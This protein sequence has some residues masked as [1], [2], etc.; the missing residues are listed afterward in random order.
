MVV[1]G[2]RVVGGERLEGE[3]GG[4]TVARM[5]KNKSD[6]KKKKKKKT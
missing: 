2:Q 6:L 3:K 1:G 5:L 4:E